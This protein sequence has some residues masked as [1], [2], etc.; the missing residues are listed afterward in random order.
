MPDLFQR[1]DITPMLI[2]ENVPLFSDPD[3]RYELKWDGERCLAYLDPENGTDLRSRR[4]LPLLSRFP[5]LTYLHHQVSGK[6]LLDGELVCIL[7]GKPSFEA[8][9]QRSLLRQPLR[10][11]RESRTHPA[12][13][14]VFDIL[15]VDGRELFSLPWTERRSILEQCVSQS[16]RMALSQVWPADQAEALYQLIL[17]QNLEG[18]VAKQ[19]DS[20][21]FPGKRTRGWVKVKPLPEDDFV[22]AGLSR[23]PNGR[24]VLLLGQ[25]QGSALRYCGKV[26]L[27]SRSLVLPILQQLPALER[28]PFADPMPQ[29]SSGITWL[30]PILVCSVS[31]MYRTSSGGM[32]QPVF[33]GL[34]PDKRPKECRFPENKF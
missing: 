16:P 7:D 27:H 8:I 4:N 10:I 12:S 13:L 29:D 34:R 26:S 2:A 14:I 18:L 1:R 17:A 25:Y 3:W 28:P 24:M 5:E 21:Y 30:S 33:R 11:E 19:Q 9:Q 15:Y 6:F 32:Q 20:R 22:I 31:C 23:K